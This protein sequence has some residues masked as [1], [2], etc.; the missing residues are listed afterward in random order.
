MFGVCVCVCMCFEFMGV[1]ASGAFV[2]VRGQHC[3]VGSLCLSV[4]SRDRTQ[5]VRLGGKC[6]DLLSPL[7]AFQRVHLKLIS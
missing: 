5:A 6:P 2:E 1:H 7:S 4:G 3:H